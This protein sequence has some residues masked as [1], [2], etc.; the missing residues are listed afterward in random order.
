MVTGLPGNSECQR[1]ISILNPDI[2]EKPTTDEQLDLFY[3]LKND[4]SSFLG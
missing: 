2:F 1:M 4:S 3:N